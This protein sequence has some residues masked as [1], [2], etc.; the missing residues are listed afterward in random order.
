MGWAA[1]LSALKQ[2]GL[3]KRWERC[4]QL[5]EGVQN[6][7]LDLGFELLAEVSQRSSTVTAILYP[8]GSMMIG[9][10]I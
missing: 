1:A 5:A 6:L 7:F 2:E 10:V 4:Q 8:E 9:V 3:E